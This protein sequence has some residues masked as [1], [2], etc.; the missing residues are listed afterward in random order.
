MSGCCD[1]AKRASAQ[2]AITS[3]NPV[4]FYRVDAWQ[5]A[6]AQLVYSTSSWQPAPPDLQTTSYMV[7]VPFPALGEYVVR[8]VGARAAMGPNIDPTK[9]NPFLP[10]NEQSFLAVDMA[11]NAG[12]TDVPGELLTVASEHNWQ[13]CE[14][15]M[16]SS[17]D[18]CDQDLWPGATWLQHSSAAA[19]VYGNHLDLIDCWDGQTPRVFSRENQA[20]TLDRD[21]THAMDP[22]NA[23]QVHPFAALFCGLVENMMPFNTRDCSASTPVC[24]DSDGDGEPDDT[25]CEPHDPTIHHP[26]YDVLSPHYDPFPESQNCC[27]Y[28]LVYEDPLTRMSVIVEPTH[29]HKSTC[30]DGIDQDCNGSDEACFY[31]SDCD[32]FGAASSHSSTGAACTSATNSAPRNNDCNDCDP[33]INPAAREQCHDGI[34]NNCNGL[35]DEGCTSCDRDGD[36]FERLD[37]ASGCPDSLYDQSKGFDCNDEDA[38]VFPGMTAATR[39]P[40]PT[41]AA[42]VQLRT[43]SGTLGGNIAC[44]MRAACRN[45]NPNGSVQV[46][47]CNLGSVPIPGDI[48]FCPP[49]DCDA[50]GDGFVDFHKVGQF[51]CV[52]FANA[53][54]AIFGTND[55]DDNDAHTFPGAPETCRSQSTQAINDCVTRLVVSTKSAAC[56]MAG[57]DADGDGYADAYDC[58]PFD[59][60]VHPFAIELCDGVDNDCDGLTDEGNPDSIGK[61]M[62]D[63][64]N[65][66][67]LQCNDSNL[68][69]CGALANRGDCVCSAFSVS[70][71][72]FN[73]SDRLACPGETAAIDNSPSSAPAPRCFATCL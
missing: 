37:S 38:G 14:L 6:T 31:D 71:N 73:Q 63:S 13:S 61:P 59:Q 20:F 22:N 2:F 15:T 26:N 40:V 48:H 52:P 35:T 46:G 67:V 8:I 9:D 36:G 17:D 28:A 10:G 30:N 23:A 65:R 41:S 49:A 12:V 69:S 5:K 44:A 32:T 68:G 24:P 50:D 33:T 4:D 43:C 72:Q 60:L 25:D 57:P 21:P 45:R 56:A 53:E 16:N 1:P 27:A 42:T 39:L 3:E 34:D 18:D 47:D 62:I 7:I 54:F 29:C 51:D 19:A 66:T 11:A 64:A 70:G 58:A 55:C